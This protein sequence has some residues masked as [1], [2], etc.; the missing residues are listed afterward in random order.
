MSH[1]ESVEEVSPVADAVAL[2]GLVYVPSFTAVTEK[3]VDCVPSAVKDIVL[4]ADSQLR[5]LEGFKVTVTS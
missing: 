5:P 3:L 1:V 2:N 4:T